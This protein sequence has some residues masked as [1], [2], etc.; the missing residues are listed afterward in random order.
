MLL[1]LALPLA[2]HAQQPFE[3]FGV[4]V[5]V[6][7]LSNGRYPEFFGN[8]S[9]RRIGSVVYNTRLRRIAYLLPGDSLL[10]RAKSEVTSRW[11]AVDPLAEKYSYITPYAY[12]NNNPVRYM[13]HDGREIVDSKGKAVTINKD[14]GFS[15]AGKDASIIQFVGEM[16]KNDAG[17]ETLTGL[18]SVATKVSV[19]ITEE[20][21]E[22]Y[23]DLNGKQLLG[24]TDLST[25][26]M[27]DP[28]TGK[29]VYKSAAIT[30]F[31]G[32]YKDGVEKKEGEYAESSEGK[33]VNGV[34]TH[35]GRHVLNNLEALKG[36]KQTGAT[37]R[38][39]EQK[40]K[41]AIEVIPNQEEKK[42]NATYPQ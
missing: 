5:K 15:Y 13:D 36:A 24:H 35:E 34:G 20:T 2:A 18:V 30:L 32:S 29:E 17:R 39:L 37:G 31:K 9:L 21:G 40:Q 12:G 25:G 27:I 38:D 3:R 28:K 4:K 10:G 6:V 41:D 11:F 26:T 19:E 14:G 23:R 7:T 8:D 22:A 16:S 33:F 42:A 1:G